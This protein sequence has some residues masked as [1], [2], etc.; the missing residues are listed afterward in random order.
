MNLNM[1][2]TTIINNIQLLHGLF[3]F[4]Y[5]KGRIHVNRVVVCSKSIEIGKINKK[6]T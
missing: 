1:H 4:G 2:E 5:G 6:T 3:H